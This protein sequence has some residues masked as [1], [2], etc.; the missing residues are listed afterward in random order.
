MA[1]RLFG[2]YA[3]VTGA[4]SGIG[5]AIALRFAHEGAVVCITGRDR[6]RANAVQ[7]EIAALG[8]ISHVLLAD[9]TAETSVTSL[10][11]DCAVTMGS[12]TILVNN[13]AASTHDDDSVTELTTDAW[14]AAFLTNVTAPMWACRASIPHMQQARRGAIINISSRQS[15]RAS[16]NFTAYV[17]SKSA[18]NGLTRA[19]A[20][21]YAQ[22]NIRCNT[23]SPGY[24]INDRRDAA[25][26]DA[27]RA[28]REA[29]HLTRLGTAADI[30]HAAV[31]LASLE[32]E[33]LTGINLQ[34][35][36]GSSNAR[37]A[38]LG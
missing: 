6:D 1:N 28:R 31:Y 10:I 33:Y 7:S 23:I 24:V 35:D 32:S 15:E 16:K 27:T 3:V 2:E 36:G 14:D 8:G 13:A 12:L 18:L 4:T 26:D 34:L 29:M 22:H 19:I 21:D 37:A 38:T 9:L 11:N 30:A 5:R 20:V 17:A 25:I